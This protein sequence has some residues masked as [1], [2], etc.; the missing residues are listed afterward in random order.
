MCSS[1]SGLSSS[2]FLGFQ[3]ITEIE[4]SGRV[5]PPGSDVFTVILYEVINDKSVAL[6]NLRTHEC[7]TSSTFASCYVDVKDS[8]NSKLRTLVLDLGQDEERVYGCNMSVLEAGRIKMLSWSLRVH[9]NSKCMICMIVVVIIISSS[10][11]S[12]KG[13][14]VIIDYEIVCVALFILLR[15]ALKVHARSSTVLLIVCEQ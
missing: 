8:R 7:T 10:S 12:R 9:L 3:D 14:T 2:L 13:A 15:L 6:M 11:G 4:C 1:L 5:L